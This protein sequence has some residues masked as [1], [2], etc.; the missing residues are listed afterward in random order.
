MKM[1]G[2]FAFME[3]IKIEKKITLKS[4]QKNKH[5]LFYYLKQVVS[6]YPDTY[7]GH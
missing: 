1:L 7:E 5:P 3:N 4:W 2:L 6:K